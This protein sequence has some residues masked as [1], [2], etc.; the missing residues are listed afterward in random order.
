MGKRSAFDRTPRDLYETPAKAVEPLLRRLKPYTWFI[1]PCDG[2]GALTRA[3]EAAGHVC[4]QRRDLP[5]D[6]RTH[7]YGVMPDEI[8]ITN[9]PYWGQP[10]DLHPLIE[11]LSN[12]APTWLLMPTDW[13]FN[14]S[15][16][17]LTRRLRRIIAVGRVKWVPGSPYTG[18]D[19]AAWLLFDRHA[20]PA[21]F[22]VGRY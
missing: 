14:K 19:N 20:K 22:F 7:D 5:F 6:A 21:G 15:S 9:P 3:L 4:V 13:L 11:N 8:F 10:K 18:Q 1:E 12:Q 2:G 17:P 16:A